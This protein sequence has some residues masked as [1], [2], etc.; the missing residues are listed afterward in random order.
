MLWVLTET[1]NDYNQH[2]DYYINA[3]NHLPTPAELMEHGVREQEVD[4]VLAGGGRVACEDAWY[5]LQAV[6]TVTQRHKKGSFE[7]VFGHLDMTPD[8][9]GNTLIAMREEIKRLTARALTPLTEDQ[10]AVILKKHAAIYGDKQYQPARWVIEALIEASQ[11]TE[12]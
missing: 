6:G 10:A 8:D 11:Q 1:Y 5:N 4:H 3:W 2:G 9:V 7:A 12:R